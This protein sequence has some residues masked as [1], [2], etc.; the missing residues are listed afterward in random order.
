[1]ATTT[2]RTLTLKIGF[3][4]NSTRNIAFSPMPST[5]DLSIETLVQ[6]VKTIKNNSF[7]MDDDDIDP[8]N[9]AWKPYLTTSD[10][11]YTA[12]GIVGATY[13]T[14]TTENIYNFN[15]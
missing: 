2:T 8:D 10:G 3:A 7:T 12:T 6:R 5:S 13:S 15:A 4:D 14:V 11:A 9:V 1:M